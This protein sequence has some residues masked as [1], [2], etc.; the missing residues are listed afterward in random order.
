VSFDTIAG[1]PVGVRMLDLLV[2]DGF[3]GARPFVDL[4]EA[5]LYEIVTTAAEQV[6][7]EKWSA[8]PGRTWPWEERAAADEV[9]RLA[10]AVPASAAAR[11]WS[12]TVFARP[13]VWIGPATAEPVDGM[14]ARGLAGKP[15]TAIWTSSALAGQPSAWWPVMRDGADGPPP[16]GPQSIWRI[17]PHPDARVFEIRAPEDW[18]WLC[19]AFPGPLRDGLVLPDWEAAQERF[20]GIHLTVEGLIRVQG[21]RVETAHGP[22]MLDDWDAEA[23]AWLHWSVVDLERLGT[24]EVERTPE[25]GLGREI[26]RGLR[27]ARRQNRTDAGPAADYTA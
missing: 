5:G 16:D 1:S 10:R 6:S 21:L 15:S 3:A 4:S 20:D 14:L 27:R 26:R 24:V 19:E 8:A 23:T 17:T 18:Q 2:A 25:P 11:W 7:S 22:A 12:G 9:D 13:Q